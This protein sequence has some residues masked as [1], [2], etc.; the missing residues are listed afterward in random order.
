MRVS[1]K[2]GAKRERL[3]LVERVSGEG[4]IVEER[5]GCIPLRR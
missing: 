5:I 1:T 2:S 3:R 4:Y